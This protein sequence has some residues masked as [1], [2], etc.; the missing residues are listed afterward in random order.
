[1]GFLCCV[2][3]T[4]TMLV[5]QKFQA[6]KGRYRNVWQFA[7]YLTSSFL[8]LPLFFCVVF[9]YLY[10]AVAI[11][12]SSHFPF[13]GFLSKNVRTHTNI[14]FMARVKEKQRKILVPV[15]R[16]YALS[17]AENWIPFFHLE[18]FKDPECRRK[19]KVKRS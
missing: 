3:S 6:E 11:F 10:L 9:V 4:Y 8:F 5:E 19:R 13:F 15:S 16:R 14:L 18:E 2:H 1:M 17:L 7:P 12:F